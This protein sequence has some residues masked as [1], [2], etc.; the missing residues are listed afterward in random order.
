MQ[1]Q[2]L[3]ISPGVAM[4][5]VVV[6]ENKEAA[7]PQHLVSED[8]VE[9]EVRLFEGA[10]AKAVAETEAL[11]QQAARKFSQEVA[12]IFE[13]HKMI[14]EDQDSL[15]VPI[16]DCIR[17]Q[18]WNAARAVDWQL[19]QLIGF[20]EGLAD[21]ELMKGRA[22][23]A[24]DIRALLLR[25][26]LGQE[27]V[28]TS[29]LEEDTIIATYE[30]TPSETAKMDLEKVVGFIS[31]VGGPTAHSAI[32]ARSM[33]IPAVSQIGEIGSVL[34]NGMAVLLDGNR[35]T[36]ET[37]VTEERAA[38]FR[39]EKAEEQARAAQALTFRGKPTVTA[40][41]HR[42]QL[43]ANIGSPKDIPRVLEADAEGIGLFRSEF[44]YMDSA[45][46][47]DEETQFQAYKAVLEALAPRPVTIRTL[48][49][50]GDK[51]LPALG[52]TQEVNPFLGY[53]AIRICLD[54]PELFRTQLRALLR[55][56]AY[57][58]LRIMFPMIS[59]LEELRQAK[60]I[61][62]DVRAELK[63]AGIPISASIPVGIMIEVPGAA[64][65]A[66]DFA[67]ESDF[68]SI[69][70]NDLTQYTLAAD[71]GNPK[72]SYLYHTDHPAVLRLIRH[73]IEAAHRNGIDCGVCGE[74]GGDPALQPLLIQYGVD[75]LS[76]SAPLILPSR[77]RISGIS[78]QLS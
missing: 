75:E 22:A 60:R 34:H 7:V 4:A 68:F 50:G 58:S 27:Q 57:G 8:Q 77:M 30:L 16:E 47:P 52:L 66:D 37:D 72:V 23:D 28:D 44:L 46:L 59:E 48:D 38:Q 26:V 20:F 12:S 18:H 62:A 35:G 51:D 74:A 40:D 64:L 33:G 2:G 6:L 41:G 5:R 3:G 65:M 32:M 69:G 55:A 49:I 63:E 71:R 21:D 9:E 25:H 67:R 15:V 24:R 76:M 13:A 1:I 17:E 45:G 73:T 53:R 42:L 43:W 78:S 70:T 14:L 56:S 54:R 31:E 29:H 19:G 36:V 39:R 10:H 61:L 11:Y